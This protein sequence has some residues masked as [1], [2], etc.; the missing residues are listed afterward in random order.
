MLFPLFVFLYN[1]ITV[2]KNDGAKFFSAYSRKIELVPL[3]M[4]TIQ[5]DHSDTLSAGFD[6]YQ[7]GA[8]AIGLKV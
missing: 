3:N 4:H 8:S 1:K 7:V 5:G 2:R 6:H